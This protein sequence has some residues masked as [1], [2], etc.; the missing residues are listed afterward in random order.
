MW[1]VLAYVGVF[2]A[3]FVL[4]VGAGLVAAIG[5]EEWRDRRDAEGAAEDWHSRPTVLDSHHLYDWELHG[6]C[7]PG[8]VTLTPVQWFDVFAPGTY[9]LVFDHKTER[10]RAIFDRDLDLGGL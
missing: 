5:L 10:E 2:A 9:N 1:S 7:G 3:A 8:W 6:E 4:L